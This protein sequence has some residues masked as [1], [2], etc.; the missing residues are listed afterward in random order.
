MKYSYIVKKENEFI[1][2]EHEKD[3]SYFVLNRYGGN[4]K[5]VNNSIEIIW[6]HPVLIFKFK[7]QIIDTYETSSSQQICDF[8]NKYNSMSIE[9]VEKLYVESQNQTKTELEQE[10]ESLQQEKKELEEEI[11]IY[12][13]IRKKK[14][15][16]DEWIEKL[17]KKD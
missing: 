17:N 16:L 10:I 14:K 12:K 1:I 9:D 8:L 13:E 3:I 5:L 6:D 7:N 2:E 4:Y 15:E 11:T